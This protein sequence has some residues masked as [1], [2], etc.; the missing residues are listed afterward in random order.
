MTKD[1]IVDQILILVSEADEAQMPFISLGLL[2][3]ACYEKFDISEILHNSFIKPAM[4]KMLQYY[5]S[6]LTQKYDKWVA[7][8]QQ[9]S[10]Q[11]KD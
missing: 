2:T 11:S 4:A 7:E 10:N 8:A 9:Y 5:Y 6:D 3:I 1:E